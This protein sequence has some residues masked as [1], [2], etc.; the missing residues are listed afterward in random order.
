MSR[1]ATLVVSLVALAAL[2]GS[3]PASSATA[4]IVTTPPPISSSSSASFTFEST[5]GGISFLC[6][7]D[8][9]AVFE[10]CTSPWSYSSLADGTHVFSVKAV[11]GGGA[12]SPSTYSWTIDTV[13][14]ST[15]IAT[16]PR[17][18]STSQFA[19]FTFTSNEAN[20]SF[21]CSLDGSAG[22]LC[23]SPQSYSN[24]PL[25]SHTFTVAA[26][27][28][29]GNTGGSAEYTW[30]IVAAADQAPGAVRGLR[31]KVGYRVVRLLW[32]LP[33]DQDFNHVLVLRTGGGAGTVPVYEGGG[34]SYKDTNVN[35]ARSYRYVLV[36][37]DDAG[38]ESRGVSLTVTPNWLLLLP[39]NGS[40]VKGAA[41]FAW[42]RVPKAILY[43]VQLYRGGKKILSAWPKT[44]RLRLQR[45]WRFGGRTYSLTSGQYHWYVWPA[46]GRIRQARYGSLLGQSSFSV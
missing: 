46:F 8:A 16:G 15:S 25:G 10:P 3:A 33:S 22:S 27:D 38:N 24:L 21:T 18:T 45:H 6:K 42:V 26:T 2:I 7:L 37:Y 9:A 23:F 5:D 35:N 17:A 28:P 39:K 30:S 13:P 19:E 29:A 1:R 20:V 43:N 4:T 40:R 14:P 12:G 44:N 32:T 31:A 36:T 11:D 34:R 41:R